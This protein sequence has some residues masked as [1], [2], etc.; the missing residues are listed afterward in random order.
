MVYY[1]VSKIFF[2]FKLDFTAKIHILYANTGGLIRWGG[3]ER[4]N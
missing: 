4:R 2:S 3:N 1:K